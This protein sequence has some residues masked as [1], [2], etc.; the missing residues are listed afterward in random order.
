M[1]VYL[2][3]NATAPLEPQIA[4]IVR[5]F[6]VEEFGNEGSR[7]HEFGARAKQAVQKARDQ[8]A[9]LVGGSRD[10]VLFTSGATEANNP[11]ISTDILKSY[12]ISDIVKSNCGCAAKVG[13][14]QNTSVATCCFCNINN[15]LDLPLCAVCKRQRIVNSS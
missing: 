6:L 7:T 3:C 8:V 9:T 4:E 1:A 2:D 13:W 12:R 5:T 11:P 10:E 14:C 15:Y